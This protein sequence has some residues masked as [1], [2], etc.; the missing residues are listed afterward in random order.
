MFEG[1]ST[2]WLLENILTHPAST[3][4]YIDTFA[5]GAEH[6]SRDLTNL[7]ARF[8]A[9]TEPHRAKLVAKKGPSAA[10]LRELPLGR[11]D[12]V[13]IDGSHEAAACGSK[14]TRY[15]SRRSLQLHF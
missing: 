13:S 4:T 12:F 5:G 15:Y 2:V 11:Y 9:N 10:M 3:L 7:E 8:R 1:R 6:A 14:Q